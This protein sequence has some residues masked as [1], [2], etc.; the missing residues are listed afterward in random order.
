MWT[1]KDKEVAKTYNKSQMAKVVGLN[2]DTLRRII[3]GKQE[4][5][6]LV[7]YCITKFLNSEAEIEDYFNLV[8]EA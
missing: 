3:N 7:A 2:A 8:K 4:C 5:S 6:K 1:F